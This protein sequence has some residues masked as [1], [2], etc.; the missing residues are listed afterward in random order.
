MAFDPGL[1]ALLRRKLADAG[2]V[3]ERRMFGALSSMLDGNMA[4]GALDDAGISGGT[5]RRGRGAR[6]SGV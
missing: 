4:S 1:A 6:S 3:A 5:G 2:P